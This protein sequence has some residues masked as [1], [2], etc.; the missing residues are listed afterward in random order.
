MTRRIENRSLPD[1]RPRAFTLVELLVVISIIGILAAMLLPT[2]AR[3]KD[4]AHQVK[5][6]SN[7]KQ[8][9]YA[10]TM[11]AD[12]HEQRLPGPIWQG[13]YD[14]YNEETERLPFYLASYLGLPAPSRQVRIAE[15]CICPAAAIKNKPASPSEPVES[16][17][18]PISYLASAEITNAI[19]DSVTR[20]F[21]YPYSSP[22][23]R[24]PKGPDEPP[25]KIVEI[26][27]PATSWA[28]S[29]LD[30]QNG[31]PGGLYYEFLSEQKVHVT[32]RNRLFFDWHV[33]AAKD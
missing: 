33:A 17:V 22:F 12:D 20:P 27:G 4:K 10:I 9:G 3:S 6:A 2:L 31:F 29:D 32:V 11:F 19:N 23:Y 28:I 21:G 7:L 24:L 1:A 25:K 26:K 5:C 30:R 18:R 15:V 13:V 14:A 8:V 16:L